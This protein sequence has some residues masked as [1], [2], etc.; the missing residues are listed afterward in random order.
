MLEDLLRA[1]AK[2][3]HRTYDNHATDD[4]MRRLAVRIAQ[5]SAL[6]PT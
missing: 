3:L 2:A 6:G 5:E 4:F 1:E